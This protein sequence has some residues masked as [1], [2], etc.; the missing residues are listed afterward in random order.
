MSKKWKTAVGIA[1]IWM[2]GLVFSGSS[3][4]QDLIIYPKEGQSQE[5]QQAQQQAAYE[6]NMSN[7]NRA[8]GACLESKGYT[9]K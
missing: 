6:Q 5:Q 4:A 1:L 2:T 7:F 8:Y 9:V 3:F